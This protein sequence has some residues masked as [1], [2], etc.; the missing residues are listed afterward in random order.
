[1]SS[2][3]E[4]ALS[5]LGAQPVENPAAGGST[6]WLAADPAPGQST[7]DALVKAWLATYRSYNTIDAYRCDLRAWTT[8]CARLSPP[9][10]P[11]RADARHGDGFAEFLR[12]SGLT[13]RTRL[14]RLAAVGSFYRFAVAA[15][16][17][18]DNPLQ[19]TGRPPAPGARG[20]R[21]NPAQARA[22]LDCADAS[23][24]PEAPRDRV[25]LRLL[26]RCDLGVQQICAA[27]LADLVLAPYPVLS[28]RGYGTPRREVPLPTDVL[29]AARAYLPHRTDPAAAWRAEE[30]P[31]PAQDPRAPLFYLQRPRLLGRQR[32]SRG[33]RI[34]RYAISTRI[35][36]YAQDLGPAAGVRAGLAALL[37]PQDLRGLLG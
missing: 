37:G 15:G 18:A 27:N 4:R 8:Y 29:D 9:V 32:I 35:Q 24:R 19:F 16:A 17:R 25:I 33:T 14:R 20:P 13:D 28:V 26:A 31:D 34:T 12:A 30:E 22:L 5:T 6:G 1:M 11:L 23:D 7:Y 2:A 3:A 36:A 10:D 21:L